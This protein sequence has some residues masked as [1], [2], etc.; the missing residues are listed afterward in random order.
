MTKYVKWYV[1]LTKWKPTREEWLKITASIG[2]D[3]LIKINRFVFKEDSTSSLIGQALIRKFLSQA[4]GKPSNEIKLT[5]T[6]HGRPVISELY[7]QSLGLSWPRVLDFNVSHSGSYCV[8]VGLSSNNECDPSMTVGVD[9]TKIVSKAS[10]EEL[11]RFL[12]LMS[13]RQFLPQEWEAV[14]TATSDRQKCINFTRLWCLKESF[15]KSNG[16]GL[17]FGLGRI[18]FELGERW[19]YNINTDILKNNILSDTMVSIDNKKSLDWYFQETAL[20]DE[21]LIAIGY[22]VR[23][24]PE[25]N[26]RDSR[27]IDR[28]DKNAFVEITIDSLL[29]SIVPL[30]E[31]DEVNWF[32]YNQKRH[33]S[34]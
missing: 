29:A 20:D 30:R 9:V 12:D 19:R 8:L 17:S 32:N 24:V 14:T 11:S 25:Y 18:C 1:N 10:E 34:Y 6:A 27:W 31:F 22:N 5:R 28:I 7:R 23:D 15:I 16:L 26:T 3:E 33:K 21:H 2:E 13:R 4:I